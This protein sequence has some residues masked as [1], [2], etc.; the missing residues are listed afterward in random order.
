MN[1]ELKVPAALAIMLL[2]FAAMVLWCGKPQDDAGAETAH[3]DFSD[4]D[5][6]ILDR[7]HTP[8]LTGL[9]SPSDEPATLTADETAS[10]DEGWLSWL[11]GTDSADADLVS[12]NKQTAT[13]A[14][15]ESKPQ[16][17]LNQK[18]I[19][20]RPVE[21]G[22]A[23]GRVAGNAVDD[24]KLWLSNRG[25]DDLSQETFGSN[26][27]IPA[28]IQPETP[29]VVTT[30]PQPRHNEGWD[31]VAPS[32]AKELKQH[33]IRPQGASQ[34]T[35]MIQPGDTL[36]RIAAKFLD[37]SHRAVDIYEANR[38]VLDNPN[39]LR[40]GTEI[41]IPNR[42]VAPAK[43]IV[44][45]NGPVAENPS[46]SRS[47][48][49]S[50]RDSLFVPVS[51]R[52]LRNTV[53]DSSGDSEATST[54]T[55]APREYKVRRGDSLERIAVKFYGSRRKALDI[56]RANAEHLSSPNAIREGMTLTLP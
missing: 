5:A 51:S 45:P 17:R 25:D 42:Q 16:S 7:P 8:H 41:V 24:A 21:S 31:V 30:D 49:S 27:E 19:T 33:P 1:R 52:P 36:S 15:G 18:L 47:E 10:E 32:V 3:E 14:T 23:L 35:Y 44:K 26:T 46:A 13:D 50:S 53:R 6:E 56:F 11:N 38:D 2:G 34:R 4:I 54:Q 40:V 12:D 22:N 37:G 29:S 39:Q 28:P 9:E 55:A 43:P 20:S 48:R